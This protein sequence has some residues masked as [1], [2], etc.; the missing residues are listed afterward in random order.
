MDNLESVFCSNMPSPAQD[1]RIDEDEDEVCIPGA[2]RC[3]YMH[4]RR[5][6]DPE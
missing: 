2:R 1:R 4:S 5:R 3:E 6:K